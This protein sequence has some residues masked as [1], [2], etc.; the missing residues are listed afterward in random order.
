MIT[1]FVNI[2]L[3]VFFGS[4][5][6]TNIEKQIIAIVQKWQ[7]EGTFSKFQCYICEMFQ[8]DFA[9][10]HALLGYKT[11]CFEPGTVTKR[12]RWVKR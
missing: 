3:E 8:M 10:K 4:L 9:S 12:R 6:K 2:S 7:V 1:D 5:L 11:L